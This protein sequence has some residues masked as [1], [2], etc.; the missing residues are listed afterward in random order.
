[1]FLNFDVIDKITNK[2]FT[3]NKIYPYVNI[4]NILHD[5]FYE[6]LR[7]TLPDINNFKKAEGVARNYGQNPH[8]RYGYGGW[9]DKNLKISTSWKKFIKELKSN[10]Y[11]KFLSRLFGTENFAIR[12]MWHYATKNQSVSP[13]FDSPR[14]LGSHIFYFNDENWNPSWGGQTTLYFDEKNKISK[15]S[16]P[17]PKDFDSFFSS[18]ISKNCSLI[19]KNT[20][21]SWHGVSPLE[22]PEGIYRKVFILVIENENK[23][24]KF[25]RIFTGYP[26]R[27][28]I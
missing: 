3:E 1:M 8:N 17:S 22:C 28:V 18:E 23:F 15:K 11:K 10:R 12:F 7:K 2:D 21:K 20:D 26:F 6:D 14:K 24:E 5:T 9:T 25:K 16:N 27:D 4:R 13:H 19:F